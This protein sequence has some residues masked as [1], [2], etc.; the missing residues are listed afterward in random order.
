MRKRNIQAFVLF[1]VSGI[2]LASL[3]D[4]IKKSRRVFLFFVLESFLLGGWARLCCAALAGRKG[5][6]E[7]SLLG[8]ASA[9]PRF[10]TAFTRAN[11]EAD[12]C[13]FSCVLDSKYNKSSPSVSVSRFCACYF[14][15]ST[16]CG[17]WWEPGAGGTKAPGFCCAHS[18]Q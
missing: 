6:P 18:G 1:H 12:V 14:S 5:T 16:G 7:A 17:M 9:P 4:A 11:A 3:W 8:E 2:V 15:Q 10:G 13:H